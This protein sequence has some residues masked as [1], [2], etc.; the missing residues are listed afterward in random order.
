MQ[1]KHINRPNK[2]L[3]ELTSVFGLRPLLFDENLPYGTTRIKDG[4]SSWYAI[5]INDNASEFVLIDGGMDK[6]AS[7]LDIFMAS[8][9]LRNDSVKA[10]LLTHVHS[11]HVGVLH[12]LQ[13]NVPVFVSKP[14][15]KVLLGS[16]ISEGLIPR[17]LDKLTRRRHSAVSGVNPTII[18]HDQEISLGSLHIRAIMMSGHTTGSVAYLVR[19]GDK[20]QP[21]IL[22]VGDALDFKKD[23]SVANANWLFTADNAS[24]ARSIV[25]TTDLIVSRGIP[26]SVV[27]PSHSGHGDFSALQAFRLSK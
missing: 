15:S 6:T 7:K 22:F 13:K 3:P 2:I 16:A 5:P 9:A 23:G 1:N 26:V 12:K 4:Y 27:V 19:R 14:D 25:D 21:S 17:M 8:R 10:V 20:E 24:S 18:S 11:D